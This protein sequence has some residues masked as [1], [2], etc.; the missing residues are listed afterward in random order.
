MV[1]FYCTQTHANSRFTQQYTGIEKKL[2]GNQ[3]VQ[4]KFEACVQEYAVWV[5]EH[6]ADR[7]VISYTIMETLNT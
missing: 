6:Q 3:L 7:G 2:Q 5:F 4:I 1:S